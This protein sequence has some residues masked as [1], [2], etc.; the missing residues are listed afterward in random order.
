MPRTSDNSKIIVWMPDLGEAGCVCARYS[1]ERSWVEFR[2][3]P[4]SRWELGGTSH[5]QQ[6]HN[7]LDG[8][9]ASVLH[10]GEILAL[11]PEHRE[12]AFVRRMLD[13]AIDR[14]E[15]V[16][17][18]DLANEDVVAVPRPTDRPLD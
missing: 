8:W 1:G 5:F 15:E 4:Y 7:A 6:L 2:G 14:R 18:D 10:S 17:A 3:P 13:E 12:Y 9:Q 16:R 11:L